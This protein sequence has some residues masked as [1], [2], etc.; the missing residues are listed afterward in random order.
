VHADIPINGCIFYFSGTGNT[1]IISNLLKEEFLKYKV[2][3]DLLAIEDVLKHKKSLNTKYDIIGFGNPVHAFS[4]PRIFFE[5]LKMLPKIKEIP[6][7]YFKTAGDPLFK[8]GDT[9]RIRKKLKRKGYQVFHETLFVMPS[10]IIFAYENELV[11]QLY[12]AAKKKIKNTVKQILDRKTLLQRNNS[13]LRTLSYL[14]SKAESYGGLYFGKYLYV[15]ESCNHC[16]LCIKNC[17]TRNIY[18]D[19]EIIRFRKNC[20]FCMRCVYLCPL[21]SI[22]N[23]YMNFFIIKG[24]YN[25]NQIILNSKLKGKFITDKTK[26]YFKHFYK[27]L[28]SE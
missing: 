20:T 24:G 6:S 4:A 12:E 10:N 11:I 16:K 2:N 13:I 28:T 7:F 9:S 1:K 27:Y 22:R 19:K 17:P 5:F 23:R 18:Y 8:G 14:F 15:T 3:I 25:L 21:K 26:G